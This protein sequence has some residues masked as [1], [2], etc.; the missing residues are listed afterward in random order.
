MA[1]QIEIE[2]ECGGTFT[3]SLFEEGAPETCDFI[4]GLLPLEVKAERSVMSGGL[5]SI[6][7]EGTDFNKLEYVNTMI[8]VGEIGFLTT[9]LPHRPM[10]QPYTQILIPIGNNQAHQMWGI[11]SPVNR[12]AALSDGSLADMV[13]VGARIRAQGPEKVTLRQKSA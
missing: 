12:F 8:P 6:P 11:A 1:R 7:L 4:W 10:N 2:F 9:F 3:V 5:I 13:E